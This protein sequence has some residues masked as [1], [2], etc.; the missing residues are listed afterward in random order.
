LVVYQE[1]LHDA[2]STKYKIS[3]YKSLIILLVIALILTAANIPFH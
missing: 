2:R 3:L 1:S